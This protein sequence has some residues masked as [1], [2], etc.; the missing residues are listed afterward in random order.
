MKKT[1]KYAVKIMATVI[2]TIEVEAKTEKAAIEQAHSLFTVVCNEGE[3]EYYNEEMVDIE[4]I[5]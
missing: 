4:R 1:K 3:A 2:K 5:D